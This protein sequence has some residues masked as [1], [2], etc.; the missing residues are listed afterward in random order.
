MGLANST[1][2]VS[3]EEKLQFLETKVIKPCT[4]H[5][6]DCL[7]YCAIPDCDKCPY[8]CQDCARE[9]IHQHEDGIYNH[10]EFLKAIVTL[11]ELKR[12]EGRQSLGISTSAATV[13]DYSSLYN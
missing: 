8:L 13:P 10:E 6:K 5:R 9:N 2:K 11:I 1:T 3:V 4:Y 12:A 7:F